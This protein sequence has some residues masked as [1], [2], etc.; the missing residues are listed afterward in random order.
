MTCHEKLLSVQARLKAPKGQVNKFGGYSYRSCEDILE[1]VKPILSEVGA[2]IT[3][4]DE[5]MMVGNRYYIRATASFTDVETG[6][7]VTNTAYARE[8]ESRKGMDASQITGTASSYARK[9]A[10][11]G[12]LCIDDTRDADT[13]ENRKEPEGKGTSGRGRKTDSKKPDGQ[14]GADGKA[15]VPITGEQYLELMPML[16]EAGLTETKVASAYGLKSLKD[17][18]ADRYDSVVKRISLTVE[19]KKKEG[20]RNEQG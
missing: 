5:I 12:L 15:T 17:L 16:K 11:N 6:Q 18:P 14:K 19:Q 3:A 10:L 1:A 9:Y 8:E 13:D 20:G 7:T 4:G 2:I